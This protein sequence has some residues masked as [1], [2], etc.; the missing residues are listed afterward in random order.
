M[1]IVICEFMDET[2]VAALAVRFDVRYALA[3]GC[4]GRGGVEDGRHHRR[5]TA[6][7]RNA[8][9]LDAAQTAHALG[10]AASQAGRVKNGLTSSLGPPH[11][12]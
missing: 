11:R 2:A 8:L 4:A 3:H 1:R 6:E 5:S 10:I 7:Q 12:R 9:G